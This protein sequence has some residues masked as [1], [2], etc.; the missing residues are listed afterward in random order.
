M[1]AADFRIQTTQPDSPSAGVVGIYSNSS[2]ILIAKNEYGTTYQVG[3]QSTGNIAMAGQTVATGFGYFPS[4]V[5]PN[6]VTGVFYGSTGTYKVPTLLGT[7]AGFLPFI[8]PSGELIA[9]PY[10]TRS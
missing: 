9:I 2:G 6:A 7:P 3:T 10:F 5:L 4:N 1:K 8:G